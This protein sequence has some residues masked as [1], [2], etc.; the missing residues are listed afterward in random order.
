[1]VLLIGER[2]IVSDTHRT[3]AERSLERPAFDGLFAGS[4]SHANAW[5]LCQTVET[6]SLKDG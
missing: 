3:R 5:C 6:V 4:Y 1:M 2:Q